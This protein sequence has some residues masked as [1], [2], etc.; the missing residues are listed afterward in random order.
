LVFIGPF[1]RAARTCAA[2]L[3]AVLMALMVRCL[4]AI[5]DRI[6]P[7]HQISTVA[8]ITDAVISALYFSLKQCV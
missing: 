5:F 1:L 7:N 2:A 8:D 4:R 6:R 3:A